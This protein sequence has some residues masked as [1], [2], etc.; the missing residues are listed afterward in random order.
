VTCRYR[1][2][3]NSGG[4]QQVLL[5]LI[6]PKTSVLDVGCATGYLGSRLAAK[7]CAVWGIEQDEQACASVPPGAYV[8]VL[9]ADIQGL[10]KL[11]WPPESF[12]VILAADVLE[13]LADPVSTLLLLK[14]YLRN[15]GHLLVSVPNIAHISTRFGLLRGNF[16]YETTGILDRT[17][18]HL[19]TFATA[20]DLLA[21]AGFKPRRV[22]AGSDRF[23]TM[24][25]R[26]PWLARPMRGLLAYNIVIE[27][28]PSRQ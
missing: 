10:Q 6:P 1:F 7:G 25:N 26:H 20:L 13:H 3:P 8:D 21:T 17:H 18:F 14:R 23:G 9:C 12:D 24:L 4:S 15:G 11:P 2:D 22:L 19:Y 16:R 27:A 28:E 5:A